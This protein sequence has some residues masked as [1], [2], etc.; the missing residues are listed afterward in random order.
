[1]L[2]SMI[3]AMTED[4]VIGSEDGSIPWNLPRDKEHFRSYTTGKWML[5]GRKTYEEMDGWFTTQV[6]IIVTRQPDYSPPAL[7]RIAHS[8]TDAIAIAR[9]NGATEL[10]VGGGSEIFAAAMPFS[11]RLIITR[12]DGTIP[13]EKPVFFPKFKSPGQWKL[14]YRE[15]WPEDSANLSAMTLE[16]WNKQVLAGQ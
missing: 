16:I 8:V 7:H 6:P 3:A 11:D 13:A 14:Q 4:D 1:M 5:I 12:I 15:R 10:V 9:E 2:I